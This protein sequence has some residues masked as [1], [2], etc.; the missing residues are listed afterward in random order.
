MTWRISEQSPGGE[1]L[2]KERPGCVQTS[3]ALQT[4]K[5]EL[6]SSAFDGGEAWVPH[7]VQGMP[8]LKPGD[9]PAARASF[10]GV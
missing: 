9:M 6:S 8:S 5:T 1:Q 3:D 10:T 2:H 4:Q 7:H